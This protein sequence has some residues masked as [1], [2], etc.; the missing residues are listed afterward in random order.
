MPQN[1]SPSAEEAARNA[2]DLAAAKTEAQKEEAVSGL[3]GHGETLA[4]FLVGGGGGA[5]YGRAGVWRG[6]QQ[7]TL[8]LP[9]AQFVMALDCHFRTPS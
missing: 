6:I 9:R 1:A 8:A 2:A 4:L 7:A 5:V 3:R